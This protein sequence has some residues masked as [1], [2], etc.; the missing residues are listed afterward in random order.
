MSGHDISGH[1]RS[2]E[3]RSSEVRSGWVRTTR[4]YYVQPVRHYIREPFCLPVTYVAS[5]SASQPIIITNSQSAHVR[6][7]Q[8]AKLSAIQPVSEP[9]SQPYQY[10]GQS[11]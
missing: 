5:Q 4:H 3:V 11:L 10:T 7:K 2:S 9:V 6:D 1:V 8:S